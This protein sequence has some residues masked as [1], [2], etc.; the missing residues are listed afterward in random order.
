VNSEEAGYLGRL[1]VELWP[2]KRRDRGSWQG[3][4]RFRPRPPRA[5]YPEG[6]RLAACQSMAGDLF[7]ENETDIQRYADVFEHLRALALPP[8]GSLSLIRSVA[9]DM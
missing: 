7:L 2:G 1:R 9:R 5:P 6:H 4:T 3:F 8:E